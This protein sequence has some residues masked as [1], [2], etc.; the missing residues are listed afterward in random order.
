[1]LQQIGLS[2]W[3]PEALLP[4]GR[5]DRKLAAAHNGSVSLAGYP[6]DGTAPNAADA[7]VVRQLTAAPAG[8]GLYACMG[9]FVRLQAALRHG[10]RV[11]TSRSLF[12]VQGI[13]CTGFLGPGVFQ[14]L[15]PYLCSWFGGYFEV[16][17]AQC[18]RL[19][20]C[21]SFGRLHA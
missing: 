19:W 4:C 5:A 7:A 17:P 14:D 8:L 9:V 18:R 15:T 12:E 3:A 6:G 16:D 21:C 13:P 10:A 11:A 1:M 20:C 2:V